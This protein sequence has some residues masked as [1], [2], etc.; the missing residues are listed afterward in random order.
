MTKLSDE[1]RR[2]LEDCGLMSPNLV[3]LMQRFVANASITPSAVQ[4]G[5]GHSVKGVMYAAIEF[6]SEL[7]IAEFAHPDSFPETLNR[8]TGNLKDAF[9]EGGRYWGR[10]RKCLNI[11]LREASYNFLLRTTYGL[12]NIDALLETPLD[13]RV[14]KGLIRD[15]GE[16]RLP[17]WTSIIALTSEQ[18]VTYQAVAAQVAQVHY[19][20]LRANLD[21]WYYRPAVDLVA[22]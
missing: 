6:L 1:E 3:R 17:R 19:H 16:G 4:Q 21:L 8:Y 12:A 18:N 14:A 10:A 22:N 15:A 7:D 20:T 5:R 2:K 11:F 13:S 9:P